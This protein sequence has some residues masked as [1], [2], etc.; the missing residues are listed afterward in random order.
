MFNHARQ[1][2]IG[3]VRDI[4]NAVIR[5]FTLRPIETGEELCISYGDH[6]WFGDTDAH[7]EVSGEIISSEDEWF[8]NI[9]IDAAEEE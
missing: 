9:I 4:P 2:N 7:S 6:L 5:Y 8:G 1:P 3:F